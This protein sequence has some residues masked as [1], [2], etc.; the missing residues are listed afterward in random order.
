VVDE[1]NDAF[2]DLFVARMAAATLG[3]PTEE[4]TAFG[5]LAR[6]DL[7]DTLQDQVDRSV[8][9]GAR[10]VLGGAVPDGPGAF[11]PPTVLVD[12]EPGMAAFDE[13][14]FG[15]VAAVVRARDTDHAI[16]LANTTIFG[17]GAAVFTRDLERGA[18]IAARRLRA[19]NCF[20]NGLVASDPRLP[21]GGVK[22]SG[23]GRELSDL[24]IKEFVNAKTVVV[25]G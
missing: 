20:V 17:L 23:Y 7:R 5:P 6:D 15:P 19:G 9:A 4:A 3:D 12:V 13:E 21:F 10:L 18:D 16:E 11:Y 22:E 25:A 8:A 1:V 2:V 14:T 24:G